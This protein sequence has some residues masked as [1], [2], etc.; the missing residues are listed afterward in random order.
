MTTVSSVSQQRYNG[1]DVDGAHRWFVDHA[2]YADATRDARRRE[3]LRERLDL[4]VAKLLSSL[5][6]RPE[7]AWKPPPSPA[8]IA[9]AMR[10]KLAKARM[11]AAMRAWPGGERRSA[12][13][14]LRDMEKA[15]ATDRPNAHRV[16]IVDGND[17]ATPAT[18]PPATVIEIASPT[19]FNDASVAVEDDTLPADERERVVVW[20]HTKRTYQPSNLIRK[21]RHGFRARLTSIGGRR[22]LRRR[23]AKGRRSLSA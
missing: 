2:A 19:E 20:A 18:E 13:G 9:D 7:E 1:A 21:R 5:E 15:W 3:D 12:E 11:R 16:P 8:A 17:H 4:P 23:R 14:I 10:M 6:I 22:V